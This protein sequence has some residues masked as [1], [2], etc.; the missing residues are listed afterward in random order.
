MIKCLIS[1]HFL[2]CCPWDT[3]HFFKYFSPLSISADCSSKLKQCRHALYSNLFHRFYIILI[4]S[5]TFQCSNKNIVRTV[6]Q[7]ETT[8]L[9][10]LWSTF[11][12]CINKDICNSNVKKRCL[13]FITKKMSFLVSRSYRLYQRKHN[14]KS[15]YF[16]LSFSKIW[17]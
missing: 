3:Q 5:F 16:L 11:I 2:L 14:L 17:V 15:L 8:L 9:S 4:F 1:R 13:H 12:A 6:Y 10:Y 7:C